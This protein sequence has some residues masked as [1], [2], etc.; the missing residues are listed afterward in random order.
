M[1]V[2]FLHQNNYYF[3]LMESSRILFF[4]FIRSYISLLFT[5]HMYSLHTQNFYIHTGIKILIVYTGDY[6]YIRKSI[7]KTF[8]YNNMFSLY[9]S[10]LHFFSIRF[11]PS[12]SS[13][14][15]ALDFIEFYIENFL[16]FCILR[17]SSF[18]IQN[19]AF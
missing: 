2:L 13:S 12:S 14:T 16:C 19:L 7:G 6:D 17:K 10:C 18:Y 11:F 3:C 15:R 1:Q 9:V 5:H 8:L 4:T